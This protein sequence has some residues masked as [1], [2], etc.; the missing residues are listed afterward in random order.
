MVE[1]LEYGFRRMRDYARTICSR[2]GH[3]LNRSVP[4]SPLLPTVALSSVLPRGCEARG[5]E[6]ESEYLAAGL[7]RWEPLSA[8]S[9][10][11]LS[12]RSTQACRLLLL[13]MMTMLLLL[14]AARSSS[15]A[16]LLIE[17]R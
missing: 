15:P 6:R 4:P 9:S 14:A 7:A 5:I 12:T 10:P 11:K 2:A 16:G 1:K 13:L 8:E 3:V 17:K